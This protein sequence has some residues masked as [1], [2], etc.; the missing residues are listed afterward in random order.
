M[1]Q[2]D[3]DA[4]SRRASRRQRTLFA[5]SRPHYGKLAFNPSV[6]KGKVKGKCGMQKR[7]VQRFIIPTLYYFTQD[8]RQFENR[9][10]AQ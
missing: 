7:V 9:F 4:R 5:F 1:E 10:H 3:A 8:S 6:V 2:A